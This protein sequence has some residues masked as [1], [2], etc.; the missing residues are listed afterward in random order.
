MRR[1]TQGKQLYRVNTVVNINNL[2]TLETL[3]SA[4]TFDLERVQPPVI[5]R[6]GQPDEAYSGI[7]RGEIK[8][9][10]LPLFADQLGPFGSTTSDS[11]RTMVR[12]E[13]TRILL[14]VISFLGSAALTAATGR[15]AAL[16][17]KYA[18]AAAIETG[19]VEA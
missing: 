12:L 7:G 8:M 4:G 16:S 3:H 17:E 9:E 14:V 13:T 5:F 15:A 18:A 19:L 6:A 11:Q 1:I 2:L 10:G